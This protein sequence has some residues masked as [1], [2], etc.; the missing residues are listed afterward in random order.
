M[1]RQESNLKESKQLMEG[2]RINFTII[3][4]RINFFKYFLKI[5]FL[6]CM[7]SKK[8]NLIFK[9]LL[10]LFCL[11]KNDEMVNEVAY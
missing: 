2:G 3:F 1:T 9:F 4:Y 6:F 10:Y 5:G 11:A 8:E 7:N